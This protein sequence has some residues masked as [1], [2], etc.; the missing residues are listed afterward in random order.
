VPYFLIK[1]Y[2]KAEKALPPTIHTKVGKN[3]DYIA[4]NVIPISIIRANGSILVFYLLLLKYDSI[5]ENT[6][7]LFYIEIASNNGMFFTP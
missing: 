7:E 4:I 3:G 2:N 6:Y 5:N 1:T